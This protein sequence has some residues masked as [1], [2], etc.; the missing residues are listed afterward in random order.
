M[1]ISVTK[2]FGLEGDR[3]QR[4]AN[5]VG[6]W[7]RLGERIWADG[8]KAPIPVQFRPRV[9]SATY[10]IQAVGLAIMVYG[11][12]E[13]DLLAVVSGLVITQTTKAWFI[14]RMV[15]LYED[16]KAR[17]PAYAGWER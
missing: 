11:P 5:P 13:L 12:V 4:H 8:D 10:A 17:D 7:T 3:W 1:S 9:L 14:D 16:T 6:V 15:L 2:L